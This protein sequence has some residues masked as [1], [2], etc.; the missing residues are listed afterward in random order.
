[1]V[2]PVACKN[3]YE[4]FKK[5]R[6]RG[7][8]DTGC[9][10]FI[11]EYGEVKQERNLEAVAGWH[12]DEANTSI[13]ILVQ[14]KNKKLTSSQKHMVKELLEEIINKYPDVK[15]ENKHG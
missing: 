11:N 6:R 7:E 13:Y 14:A 12:Y 3:Y 8:L 4:Y 10:Y 9:H 5:L 15:V 1:M 2:L